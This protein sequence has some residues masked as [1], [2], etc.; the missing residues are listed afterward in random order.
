MVVDL[1]LAE[2]RLPDT[3][4]RLRA[5]AGATA[6]VALVDGGVDDDHPGLLLADDVVRRHEL[7][8]REGVR[9]VLRSMRHAYLADELRR[10]QDSARRLRNL[11]DNTPD[12]VYAI[13]PRGVITSW[14]HGSAKLFGYTRAE[15][16][17]T[18]VG[19]LH[20]PGVDEITPIM[21]VLGRGEPVRALET[22]RRT[23][24]GR[25]VHVSLTVCPVPGP[26]DRLQGATVVAHDISDRRELETELLRAFMHDGLTGLPN[27]AH[28]IDRLS[29]LLA[30]RSAQGSGQEPVAVFF[31][32]LDR[33]KRIN[34]AQGHWAGDQVLSQV[35][36]RLD[37]D[38]AGEHDMVARLG[39]D[40]SCS[41]APTPTPRPRAPSRSGSSR[42]SADRCAWRAARC[43]SAAA[44]ASR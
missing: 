26:D 18:H 29:H 17:G 13:D 15:A 12:A 10:A 14:N 9:S 6:L 37:P 4:D 16:I 36:P 41:C 31:L 27:R 44:S 38:V 7:Q 8:G 42:C 43:T 19:L 1:A 2:S 32:D 25:E 23:K 33:F 28:L 22:V 34:E 5:C 40:E 30:A 20:P 11:V 24:D 3:W 39:G 35:G 21:A